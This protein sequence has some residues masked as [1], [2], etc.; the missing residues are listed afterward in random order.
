MLQALLEFCILQPRYMH[1][2]RGNKCMQ[3]VGENKGDHVECGDM[4][5]RIILK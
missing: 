2:A 3:R 4:D 1:D 5:C